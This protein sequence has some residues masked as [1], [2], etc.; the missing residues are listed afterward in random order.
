GRRFTVDI[1]P[2]AVAACVGTKEFV[3]SVPHYLRLRDP[4]KDTVLY[5]TVA[6][7]TYEM[8]AVFAGCRAVPVPVDEHWRLD[9]SRVDDQGAAASWGRAHGVPVFSDECY[10]EFTWSG[11]GH[12]ILEHGLEGMV[13]VYSLSK[14]SN[15][16]GLRAG[17]FA[18]DPDLVHYLAEVRKHAGLM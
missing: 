12:T 4:S 8:G 15:L 16:A 6:Y 5:P 3:A 9:L 11:A 2:S 18:G 13:A 1:S 7:P 14:R 17:F 10:V